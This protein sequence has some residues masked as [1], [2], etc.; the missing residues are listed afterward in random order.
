MLSERL[1]S[2]EEHTIRE[3][4]SSCE[5]V[6]QVNESPMQKRS[7][8]FKCDKCKYSGQSSVSLNKHMN[9]KHV[10]EDIDYSN[11]K[12][13]ECVS[14]CINDLFQMEFVEGEQVY[15][16]NVCS[17]CFDKSDKIKRHIEKEHKDI[18]VQISKDIHDKD[19][20]ELNSSSNDESY[21][22]AWLAK[23]DSDGN[24]MGY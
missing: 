8:E 5:L 15:A 14:E 24:F 1:K 10:H 3:K 2:L 21:G 9:T 23:Y 7:D 17:K 22:A 4:G 20:S 18:I 13:S 16:C 12:E 6:K 19:E 11:E